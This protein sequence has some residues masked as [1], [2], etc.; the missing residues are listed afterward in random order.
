MP[1]YKKH[2]L[3]LISYTIK[4]IKS[5]IY[6]PIKDLESE[7]W[8]TKEPVSFSEKTSGEYKIGVIGESWGEL[9]DCA[10]ANIKGS[11]P[12]ENLE[13]NIVLLLDFNGE[14]CVF[15][16]EGSPLRGLTNVSSGFDYDLGMPG[17][18]VFRYLKEGEQ[19]ADINLWVELGMNDLFGEYKDGGIL[20]TLSVAICDENMRQLYYDFYV[21]YDL[22]ENISEKSARYTTILNALDDAK[23]V[24]CNYTSDEVELARIIL[25]KELDKQGPTPSLSISAIG[26]A[27]IDLAWLWPIRETKRKAGRTF[28]TVLDL[29]N[30][31]PDYVFGA[32]Q[33]QLYDW[34]K[35]DYP[36]LYDKI[37]ARIDEGRWEAQGGMWVEPDTNI[38]GGESLVRQI[39]YGKKFFKEEFNKEMKTLWLPDVFGYTGALPQI[40]KKSNI[41][42]FM[43]IKLSWSE[44][45]EFPHHTFNWEGIDG[46]NIIT[47]MPPTGTY[48]DPVTPKYIKRAEENYKDVGVTDEC[49]VLFG[50]GDGGGGPGAEHLER[51]KRVK[52]LDGLVPV[53][54]RQSI[55]FFEDLEK[56]EGISKLKKW[57]GELYLEKHQGTYTTQSKTKCYNRKLEILMREWEFV[58]SL[59]KI[60]FGDDY[61]SELIEE[62]WKEI[63]LYQFHDILPGSSIKRVYDEAEA[64]YQI[65]MELVTEKVNEKYKRISTHLSGTSSKAYA[66]FNSLSWERK[67][68]ISI[69][70]KDFKVEVPA[71]G[72]T[73]IDFDLVEDEKYNIIANKDKLENELI[74]VRFNKN[75]FI[76]SIIDKE[77]NREIIKGGI[78]NEMT[79]YYDCNNAWDIEIDYTKRVPETMKL[80]NRDYSI[81]G[82]KASIIQKFE[83][84]EIVLTQEIIIQEGSKL[85][86]F[87]TD[88]DW[89]TKNMML[90]TSFPVDIH[91]DFATCNI[92][93][94]NIKKATHENTSWDM[95]RFE[96]CAH[97]WIDISQNDYGVALL[98]DCKY[99]HN[100]R[101]N[102]L[103]INLL[104]STS[105]PGEQADQGE[106]HFE[107]AIYPH[108]GNEVTSDVVKKGYEFN[109]PMNIAKTG[110][111]IKSEEIENLISVSND[112]IIV[113]TIK[114]AEDKTGVVVRIYEPNGINQK[115]TMSTNTNF[116]K[117]SFVNL[118]EEHELEIS[119]SSEFDVD[120]MPYEIKTIKLKY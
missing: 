13:D 93:F 42:Y 88:V 65:L 29:M 55:D 16:E 1:Y 4:N 62:V 26:H 11:V 10:W 73:I 36:K 81:N 87:K 70:D 12:E 76:K 39:M 77:C 17:K 116:K 32:S 27:H 95:A 74:V 113:E 111:E 79:L 35:T 80:V 33:P 23:N 103:D 101:D 18:R 114:E 82:P 61:E 53:R 7:I 40:L 5:K 31:Y 105:Y 49:L 45:N 67:E 98:N 69:E 84:K 51:L 118:M 54:Q 83:Y 59:C 119:K 9:W 22:L 108:V 64:R 66:V 112:S 60:K 85:I 56:S 89:N 109:I 2:T 102:V 86:T 25:K 90:R 100:V 30:R 71:L 58:S 94:G 78:A 92:Q 63:L 91:S 34:V 24:L 43:T 6:T 97:K 28:S 44:H 52:N 14:A 106:H 15:D 50:I 96:V 117:A 68:W 3:E 110:N 38:T 75:G 20:K 8:L 41:D 37:K 47:H 107:Y 99:G 48:N 21:L 19:I 57:V 104:R 46:T 72:Y 120:F 115:I